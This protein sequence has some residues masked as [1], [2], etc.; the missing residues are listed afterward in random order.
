VIYDFLNYDWLLYLNYF[1]SDDLY[2]DYL[3]HFHPLFHN[4][5]HYLNHFHYLLHHFFHLHYL[6]HYL[7]DVS[8]DINWHVNYILDL[9][10]S[11]ILYYLLH[12][13]L[14]WYQNRHLNY[15]FYYFYDLVSHL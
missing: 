1:L 12:D 5:F 6:L 14:H 15:A 2:L 13:L 4:S 8:D 11:S 7:L 9:L 10:Y 3:G